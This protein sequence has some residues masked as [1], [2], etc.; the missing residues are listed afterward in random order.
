M[1]VIASRVLFDAWKLYD[2]TLTFIRAINYHIVVSVFRV[3]RD[4][5]FVFLI[6]MAAADLITQLLFK[7]RLRHFIV[8]KFYIKCNNMRE[9]KSK[10]NYIVWVYL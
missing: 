3:R 7:I 1:Q 9:R 8:I 6:Q 10:V 5:R 2:I 4:S